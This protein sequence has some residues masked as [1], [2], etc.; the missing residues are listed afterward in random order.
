MEV[1]PNLQL[2]VAS[3]GQAGLPTKC[4]GASSPVCIQVIKRA[5]MRS[6][7]VKLFLDSCLFARLVSLMRSFATIAFGNPEP[8]ASADFEL[9]LMFA[10]QKI[11]NP[12]KCFTKCFERQLFGQTEA[13]FPDARAKRFGHT[14]K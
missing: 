4:H 12:R 7:R 2:G 1:K 5:C 3:V 11:L 8:Q 14:R 13:R 9:P 10:R 6:W